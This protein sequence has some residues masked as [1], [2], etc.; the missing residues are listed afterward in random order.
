MSVL[1]DAV[2]HTMLLLSESAAALA[3]AS[4]PSMDC[5]DPNHHCFEGGRL[6]YPEHLEMVPASRFLFLLSPIRT[7]ERHVPPIWR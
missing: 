5:S 4:T 1:A 7:K 6:Q 3:S 2:S